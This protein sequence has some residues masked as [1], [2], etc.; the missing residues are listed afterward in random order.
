[1]IRHFSCSRSIL[2]LEILARTNSKQFPHSVVDVFGLK[3]MV[4]SFTPW[5]AVWDSKRS[6]ATLL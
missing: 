2:E 1:M 4:L 6:G 5:E 3:Q